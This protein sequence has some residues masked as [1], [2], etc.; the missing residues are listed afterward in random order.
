MIWGKAMAFR[1]FAPIENVD[2]AHSLGDHMGLIN[3][4]E[5]GDKRR[6]LE[7]SID[8][9]QDGFELQMEGVLGTA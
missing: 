1:L 8:H 2:L 4:I 5:T 9:I 7:A 6:A 3:V